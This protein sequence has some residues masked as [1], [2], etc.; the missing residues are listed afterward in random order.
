[1]TRH[2]IGLGFGTGLS[3]CR[4]RFVWIG[5]VVTMLAGLAGRPAY[6]LFFLL[7]DYNHDGIVSHAD[8]SVLGDTFGQSVPPG[9]GADGDGDGLVDYG[10]FDI[11]TTHYGSTASQPSVLPLAVTPS[12]V[13]GNVQWTFAFSGVNG[14]LAG[15]LNILTDGPQVV[16]ATGG[17]SFL[18]GGQ[19]PVG[20]PGKKSGGGTVSGISFAA[21]SAFAALGTTLSLSPSLHNS[22]STLEFLRLTTAGQGPTI[23]A[24]SGEYGYQG[25]D[26]TVSGTAQ[27]VPEPTGGGG[28]GGE[29]T[30]G[31]GGGGCF[32]LWGGGC[33]GGGGGGRGKKTRSLKRARREDAS[34]NGA[35]SASETPPTKNCSAGASPSRS[36]LPG[37][38][39]GGEALEGVDVL[40][41]GAGDDF[42]GELGRRAVFVPAA[43]REPVADELL[44]E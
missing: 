21:N 30:G 19:N 17:G 36:L 39:F 31:G 12:V 26:Y 15:H 5:V 3:F 33:V 28:G 1:M 8:Y 35:E 2:I 7:G 24:Y 41:A 43:G 10:D 16:S 32:F 29:R 18:D 38:G 42:G 13:G 9:F 23:L 20:V 4:G 25:I 6:G 34:G 22:N 37:E 40:G 27:F 14:A 11:Y 44:V